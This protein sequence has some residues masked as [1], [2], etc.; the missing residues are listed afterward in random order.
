MS[1]KKVK[2]AYIQNHPT[3]KLTFKKRK[4]G[5]M[6]K[7]SEITTLCDVEA[8][9]VVYGQNDTQPEVWPSPSGVQGTYAKFR[10][11]PP[12]EQ[13]K[14]QLNIEA[15]LRQQIEKAKDQLRKQKKENREKEMSIMMSQCLAGRSLQDLNMGDLNDLGWVIDHKVEEINRK[16]KKVQEE[17]AQNENNHVQV[18]PTP[19]PPPAAISGRIMHMQQAQSAAPMEI[20]TP[21][22]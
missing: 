4:K 21:Q 10:T 20:M 2:L 18:V 3:R 14:T 5:F 19:P 22:D 15:F 9:A 17:L 13:T 16:V 6:K 7:M 8:C 12:M 1:R 11:M